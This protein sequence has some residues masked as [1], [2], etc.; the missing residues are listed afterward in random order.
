MNSHQRELLLGYLLDALDDEERLAVEKQLAADSSMRAELEL[1]RRSLSPL[2]SDY[3][4]DDEEPP[5][6]LTGKTC[7]Y[8]AQASRSAPVEL[9]P[10]CEHPMRL[11]DLAVAASVLGAA[12]LVL[13]P[14]VSYS[15][16]NAEVAGCRE[17]LRKVGFALTRFSDDHGGLFPEGAPHGPLSVAGDYAPQLIRRGL[18]DEVRSLR[19]PGADA[20]RDEPFQIPTMEEV[21]AANIQERQR[22]LQ[23]L[24]GDYGYRLGYVVKDRYIPV[25]NLR[26]ESAVIMADSPDRRLD[27]SPSNHHG[28]QGQN[29]LF[30]SCR[31]QFLKPC[32]VGGDDWFLNDEE[33]VAPGKHANDIVIA[34][35]NARRVIIFIRH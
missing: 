2:A 29:Y 10:S 26:R 31:V 30:E 1:L 21:L 13:F 11:R 19:C 7:D 5:V 9:A 20:L 32:R 3:D 16:F 6:D 22:L 15:R 8:V 18:L 34:P 33:Q 35:S 12:L 24:G 25:R 27:G 17:N 28:A 14:A 4:D 23:R